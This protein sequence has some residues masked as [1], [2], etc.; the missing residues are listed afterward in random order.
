MSTDT[1]AEQVA[2]GFRDHLLRGGLLHPTSVEGLYHRSAT[3]EQIVRAIEGVVTRA[4]GRG[5][6]PLLHFPPVMPREV[7]VKSDYLRSFPDLIGSI[8][9]FTGNDRDHV[10]LLRR[11]DAGEDWTG[12][13]TPAEVTLCSAAC[14]P[15]YPGLAG[16][17]PAGGR[18]A[19]IQGYCFRH[20]PS[21]DPA[22]MQSFRQHEFVFVGEPAGAVAHRDEWLDRAAELLAG[23]GLPVE[24][25]LANDPFFGRAGR[26]LAANQRET[27][28]KFEI[29]C[30]IASDENPTAIASA[31]YHLDHFGIPFAIHTAEGA[32]AHSA[33]IGFGLE[34]ITLALLRT[35]GID[36]ADW[37]ATA[38]ARL[39]P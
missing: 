13:L 2:V 38:R 27:A 23:L 37:P 9:T 11:A 33:C 21:I 19:E 5:Y 3:F 26:M 10:E 32:P 24:K 6:E 16:R 30:P 15:L 20:E 8:E 28:L 34:R 1:T 39:W 36:P 7:L 25:V 17:L 22:R 31:N 12:S 14:H 18:R 35:H 4:G 29:V